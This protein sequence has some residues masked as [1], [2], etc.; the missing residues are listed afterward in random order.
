MLLH[1]YFAIRQVPLCGGVLASKQYYYIL[2]MEKK[3]ISTVVLVPMFFNVNY[4]LAVSGTF[5][6][7]FFLTVAK[8]NTIYC[9]L[10]LYSLLQ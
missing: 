1:S 3:V 8:T 2:T 4:T 5:F 7:L 9:L 6:F 10:Q